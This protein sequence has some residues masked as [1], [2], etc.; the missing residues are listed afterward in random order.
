MA[1]G[2][3]KAV[4]QELVT[5]RDVTIDFSQEEWGCLNSSQR[6]LYSCVMLENYRI[7][8]SLGLCFSKPSVIFL[9]EQGKEPWTVKTELTDSLSTG[10]ESVHE[11]EELI[12]KQELCEEQSPGKIMEG[13]RSLGLEYPSWLKEWSPGHHFERPPGNL[14]LVSNKRPLLWQLSLITDL[15]EVST[16]A[17][18]FK[19]TR[20]AQKMRRHTKKAHTRRS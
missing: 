5:F 18:C 10:W 13:L 6:H 3:L 7:L 1:V 11:T 17:H 4:H 2:L 19:R 8:V 16:R 14:R 9:L 20:Q 15:G 12:P